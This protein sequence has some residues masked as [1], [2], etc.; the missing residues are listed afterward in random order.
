MESLRPTGLFSE[1]ID[2]DEVD[3]TNR[4]ALDMHRPGLL[5][6]ARRQTAGRGRRGRPWFSPE[7]EN[8]TMT[9]TLAPPEERLPLIAGIAV[10]EALAG[11]VFPRSVEMKWPNDIVIGGRKVCGILCEVRGGIAAMGVGINV[12]QTAWPRG[13]DH[14]AVSLRQV[15]GGE[16]DLDEIAMLVAQGISIWVQA[17]HERGFAPVR[18]EFL[19]HGLLD[20]YEV[21]DER[22]QRCSI[23]DLTMD[24]HLVIV[25]G[26]VC[27]TLISETISIGWAE[28]ATE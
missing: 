18:Q 5:V 22:A 14:R 16:Y 3:S 2:L 12:N 23:V 26:G 6:R 7:G 10:R 21:F 11:L 27:R 25:A 20:E 24:G 13:L 4:Y 17:F 1:I 15:T 8:L 19:K 28:K 9:L